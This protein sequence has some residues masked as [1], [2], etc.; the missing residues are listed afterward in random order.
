MVTN[1][2]PSAERPAYGS[3]VKSQ[4][5][6]ISAMGHIVDLFVVEGWVS[7]WNYLSSVFSLRKVFSSG[8]HDLV[9]A[10]YGLTGIIACLQRRRPV[11][12]SFCGDDLLGASNGRGGTTLQSRLLVFLGQ[13]AALAAGGVIVKSRQMYARL[14]GP[15]RRKAAVIPNGVDF[16]MFRPMDRNA[17]RGR[18]GL[19]YDTRYV[20]F[21]NTSY[22]PRKR[23][24]LAEQ[25]VA[26][27]RRDHPEA[28]LLVVYHRPQE[29]V[30]LYMN[31]CDVMLLTSDWEGSPNV[32]KEAMACNL[33]I[34][35]VD[36]GDAWEVIGGARNCHRASRDAADLAAKLR[37]ALDAGVRSDGRER[38]G[39]L[40][41]SAVARRVTDVYR[42][43][44]A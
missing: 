42:R 39:H 31:A 10:H 14:S 22:D 19:D 16:A 2:Y 4:I 15:A 36:A 5:D 24:D 21:P 30:P 32:V 41:M 28:E 18:L 1:M 43:V 35:S 13:V 37:N 29:E 7:R 17:S 8:S 3:F 25:A 44:L 34:V 27:L 40:E 9:H 26:I 11:V 6:S 38:I 33:P 23:I 20:L 12:I